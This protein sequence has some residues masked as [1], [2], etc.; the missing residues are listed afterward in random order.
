[1]T[2][3]PGLPQPP[4]DIAGN[5]DQLRRR[6]PAERREL[7]AQFIA[8]LKSTG[9]QVYTD[10][11]TLAQ[12]SRDWW[13]LAMR[14]AT[15]GEIPALA[16]A[17][18]RPNSTAQVSKVLAACTKSVVPL[19]PA[20]GRSG[21][22]GASVPVFGGVVLDT[23]GIAGIVSVNDVSLQ[24]EVLA[25]TFGPYLEQELQQSYA[26]SIGHWPQS[27][28]LSTVGGWLACRGAGQYST[29]YG[30]IEDM[31]LGLEVVLA[32]GKVIR[33]GGAP[34]A[35]TG[36]DLTQI[37]LGS[38]G[39]LGMITSATLKAH[40]LPPVEKRHA[41]AFTGFEAGLEACRRIL[42]RGA[43]PA[44]M[45]LYDEIESERNFG[46]G[47]GCLLVVLDEGDEAIVSATMSIALEECDRSGA[48]LLGED[49]VEHWLSHRNDVS[50]LA[51]LIQAGIVVDTVE[52]SASWS[53]L[54][55]LYRAALA[56]LRSIPGMLSASAHQS[57]AY[58]SGACL[59]FTFAGRSTNGHEAPQHPAHASFGPCGPGPA[60]FDEA[61]GDSL[62]LRAF[63][64]VM[65]A[66]KQFGAAISHHHGIGLNRARFLPQALG[67]AF[68]VLVDLK[69]ALDP[70]GIL[71]PGKLSLPSPFGDV[72]WP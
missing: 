37:F 35:A 16:G 27:F 48:T 30:K 50:A 49:P 71:N 17:V 20:G 56:G 36:P 60:S 68:E 45:R 8:T 31:V 6:L 1:M 41:W 47:S 24:V 19:T 63:N 23:T 39:A 22:C 4:I 46:L 69:K 7:D 42:R 10:L 5:L 18:V 11:P 52:I 32:S 25:G 64:E 9:A 58:P 55:G 14:W 61:W 38:E 53:A 67:P 40:P 51:P 44:V 57:H 29:R 15:L 43:T 65:G 34:K 66:A 62:Y 12:A 59:Y 26:M 28:D 13:P 54:P 3:L 72:G 2:S 33:T 70:A 21:V